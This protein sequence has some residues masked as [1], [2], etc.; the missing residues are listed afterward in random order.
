MTDRLLAVVLLLVLVGCTGPDVK[1]PTTRADLE[2]IAEDDRFAVVRLRRGQGYS[3]LAEALL[4]DP[5]ERWQIL[6]VNDLPGMPGDIVAIPL[7]PI[8]ASGFFADGYRVIP[9]LCYH[10]FTA[11]DT[12]RQQLEVSEVAFREQMTYLRDNDYQ[13]IPLAHVVDILDGKRPMP[14]RAVVITVDDGYRS[15]YDYAWPILEEFGYPATHF[16]YTDFIGGSK[17]L[18]WEEI[19]EI[20]ASGLVDFQS[21]GKSHTRLSRLPGEASR[22]AYRERLQE[23][24]DAS[25]NVFDKRLGAAPVMLSYPYGDSSDMAVELLAEAD[26]QLAATVTRGDNTVYADRYLLHRTM[27]YDHHDLADF[28]KLLRNFRRK[29]LK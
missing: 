26:Y 17:A 14:P 27:I 9:I 11:G 18:T 20:A 1:Q 6:E 19:E 15:F 29:R 7:R 21:H 10:Q 22:E 13:V 23:E 12:T 3:E 25:G 2:I 4:D 24:L 28:R 16:I 8:N 5:G